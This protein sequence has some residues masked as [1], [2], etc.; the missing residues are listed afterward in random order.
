[1]ID[2]LTLLYTQNHLIIVFVLHWNLKIIESTSE[3]TSESFDNCIRTTLEP[4]YKTGFGAIVK[5]VLQ[6][7]NA[8]MINEGLNRLIH[9][10]WELNLYSRTLG[11]RP[12]YKAATW[13]IMATS[14]GPV[15]LSTE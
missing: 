2:I 3:S 15:L 9:R 5:L 6:H 12:L 10:K 14:R 1:M 7:N 11:L 4:H 13:P 8:I